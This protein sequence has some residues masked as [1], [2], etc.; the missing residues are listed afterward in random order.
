MDEIARAEPGVAHTFAISGYSSVLQANQSNVG[1][2]FVIPEDFDKRKDKS[3][4][5]QAMMDKLREKFAEIKDARILVLPPP[6]LRGLGNS[7]GFKIQV[8]DLDGAGLA[9]LD[10]ATRKLMERLPRSLASPRSS[11]AFARTRRSTSSISTAPPRRTSASRSRTSTT[12][13]RSRSARRT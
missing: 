1:A 10:A 12:R 11:P 13:C 8:Q 4:N 5:S 9:S 7:G 3:L 2:A 6:P